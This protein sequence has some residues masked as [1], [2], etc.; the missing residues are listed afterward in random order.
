ML[1]SLL[2]FEETPVL[3]EVTCM[4]GWQTRGTEDQVVAAIQRHGEETHGRRPSR[5]EILALAVDL[6]GPDAGTI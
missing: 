2:H 6:A 1:R 5:E 4:C 3:K